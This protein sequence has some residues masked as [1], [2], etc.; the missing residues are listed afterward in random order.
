LKSSF[1][2]FTKDAL[3]FLADLEENNNREWFHPRKEEFEEKLKNPLGEL[4]ACIN[5]D[6]ARFAPDYVTDAKKA[7]FRIYRDTRFSADKTPYKTHVAASFGRRGVE[8]GSGFYLSL[9]HKGVE[10]GGGAYHPA[11]PALLAIRTHIAATYEEFEKLLKDRKLKKLMGELKG[12]ELTRV[13]KGFHAEDPAAALLK[14][15]DWYFFATLD[16]AVALGP[17]LLPEVTSRFEVLTPFMEYLN[18]PLVGR[19]PAASKFF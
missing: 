16:A 11:P 5:A 2:G 13:P 18:V 10:I 9:S 17:K 12:A 15:K 1:S 3:Q 8:G 6:L 7:A 14:K 4:V 19:K